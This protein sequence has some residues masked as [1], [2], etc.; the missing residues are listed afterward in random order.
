MAS[1]NVQKFTVVWVSIKSN[2]KDKNKKKEMN[3]KKAT[4]NKTK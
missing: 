4:S 3:T 2:Q 1:S